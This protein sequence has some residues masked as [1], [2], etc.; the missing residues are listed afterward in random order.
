MGH[1]RRTLQLA[2]C[3]IH[4]G[5]VERSSSARN[6]KS[7]R[8]RGRW[9]DLG[10][11]SISGVSLLTCAFVFAYVRFNCCNTSPPRPRSGRIRQR[12]M[13]CACY[14]PTRPADA[15]ELAAHVSAVFRAAL[16]RASCSPCAHGSWMC[17][18]T[19][20]LR[21]HAGRSGVDRPGILDRTGA[22]SRSV[23]PASRPPLAS[24]GSPVFSRCH[25]GPSRDHAPWP[26][27]DVPPCCQLPRS[28]F[29]VRLLPSVHFFS[30][31]FFVAVPHLRRVCFRSL[32]TRVVRRSV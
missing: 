29:A 1:A 11:G 25:A 3:P 20:A 5:A 15:L 14:P 24:G 30:L 22:A 10:C 2:H 16:S 19:L 12:S 17:V 9:A 7:C 27:Q 21:T 8:R 13:C 31:F 28:E 23:S 32:D 6:A 26:T 18:T 4:R